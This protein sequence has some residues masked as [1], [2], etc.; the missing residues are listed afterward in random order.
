M[1]PTIALVGR[2][3]V[4]K[5][6]LFNCLT[7]TRDALVADQPGLTRDRKYGSGM[8]D[9]IPYIVID[10]GG[11]TGDETG[12]ESLMAQQSWIAVEE[13]SIVFFLVDARHGLSPLDEDIAK[14][15]RSKNKNIC[16]VINKTDGLNIDTAEADFSKLGFQNSFSISASH[17]HGVKSM[18]EMVFRDFVYEPDEDT[19]NQGIKIAIVGRPNVGKSTLVNRIIGEQRVVSFDEPGTT[20]DSIYLHFVR[21][22]KD[23][24][25]ID[26]AG[27]RR[28]SKVSEAV[29]KFSVIK[30]LQ[31]ID[32]ANVVIMLLDGHEG[33]TE[34]D[35]TLLGYVLDSGRALVI[36][37]NKWDGIDTD[38]KAKLM[39]E[40]DIKLNFIQN[41]K[42]HKI[43]ALH[44]TGV[45]ELFPSIHKAYTSATKRF[46]P[47]KLTDIMNNI[48]TA[49]QPP[50]VK[51]RR[52]KL[53]YVHQGGLNPPLFVIH[54]NQT[55]KIPEVYKRY[56]S[57]A[58]QKQLKLEGTPVRFEFKTGDN[59]FKDKKNKL[60]Q[61]QLAKRKRLMEHVKK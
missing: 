50:L 44:G 15:L 33:I 53:R 27:V 31:A 57:N 61:R 2:P 54:G 32:D 14:I 28:K 11:L 38:Q 48:V 9:T 34:Q 7:R 21:N 45:G 17:R 22:E 5:S 25:L 19:E 43:S 24:T 26:T 52:I 58:F 35:A 12:V 59:P 4:G 51:G 30:T 29:E 41:V 1:K 10:T 49:H 37:I 18:M 42:I 6:T 20:R 23:Y 39:R 13:A 40:L 46:T 36:A 56:L 60:T 47:S 3:N 8:I 16:L 55:D